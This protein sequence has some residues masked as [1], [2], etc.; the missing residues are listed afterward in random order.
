MTRT[1][2]T[3]APPDAIVAET[4][5]WTTSASPPDAAVISLFA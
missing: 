2:Q 5:P 1:V 3:H 4:T